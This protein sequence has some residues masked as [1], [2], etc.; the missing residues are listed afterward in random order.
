MPLDVKPLHK[1]SV[2]SIWHSFEAACMSP[3]AGT[4]QRREMRR[5]FY[6]GFWAMLNMG[7]AMAD[8]DLPDDDGAAELAR[9][10]KEC[11]RFAELV[12]QEKD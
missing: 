9:L 1:E 4:M 2:L 12:A 11:E 8:A 5:A 10:A 6:S 7:V 3:D